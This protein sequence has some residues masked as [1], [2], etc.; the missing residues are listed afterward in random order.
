VTVT[1]T[2]RIVP[3]VGI[4]Q[5]LDH[6]PDAVV[7]RPGRV[8]NVFARSLGEQGAD[9]RTALAWRWAFT[10]T[11][12]SPVTLTTPAGKPPRRVELLTEA[13]APAE[14]AAADSDPGGQVMH[15]RL[16]LRWLV[17]DLDAV[18]LWNAGPQ[19][20]QVNDGAASPRGRAEIEEVYNRAL[21][22]CTQ[23]P[24]PGKSRAFGW[25][26]GAR[27]LLGWA[28]GEE[29]AGPLTGLRTT[30]RP[31][32]YEISLDTRRAMTTL[33]HARHDDQ[34]SLIGRMEGTMEIFLWLTR[35]N[36]Q[37]P[38]DSQEHPGHCCTSVPTIRL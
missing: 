17:G 36:D 27:Q 2:P 18:P 10:G 4:V 7:H 38:I 19:W 9:G 8:W 34:P 25:V 12:P 35:W 32:L 6:L 21:L 26:Y 14:L 28:C 15:A 33:V 23:H 31:T 22:A 11:C 3:V 30:G 37:P 1:A 29:S 13:T 16:V 24:W 5:L 20:P